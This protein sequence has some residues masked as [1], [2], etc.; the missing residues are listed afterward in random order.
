MRLYWMWRNGWEY[1]QWV[2]F[3]S[4]AGQ[5]YTF[6]GDKNLPTGSN[7]ELD[8]IL[9]ASGTSARGSNHWNLLL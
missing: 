8:D 7:E 3:S 4:H 9:R 6:T 2:K 1:A 5:R